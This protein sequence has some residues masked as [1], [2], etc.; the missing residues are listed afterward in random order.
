MTSPTPI[1]YK[2]SLSPSKYQNDA[3]KKF[4]TEAA[5][6]TTAA[7]VPGSAG[8]TASVPGH[9]TENLAA[10]Q[11]SFFIASSSASIGQVHATDEKDAK[12]E[13]C[14]GSMTKMVIDKKVFHYKEAQPL[15]PKIHR[16][17]RVIRM[18]EKSIAKDVANIPNSV[19]VLILGAGTTPEA[20]AAI[21]EH[22]KGL[23]FEKGLTAKTV[24]KIPV[25]KN[26]N[27]DISESSPE[28]VCVLGDKFIPHIGTKMSLESA[29]KL[30]HNY[31]SLHLY[32]SPSDLVL[33]KLFF[34]FRGNNL[35]ENIS[36]HTLNT[37]QSFFN[38]DYTIDGDVVT[39]GVLFPADLADKIT[40][41]PTLRLDLN[42]SPEVAKALINYGKSI[43]ILPD[44]S[45]EAIRC[46]NQSIVYEAI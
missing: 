6:S 11:A 42:V 4:K 8:A 5:A 20:A 35:L 14:A 10:S 30:H 16:S 22:I 40:N 44:M 23:V 33:K 19:L 29:S 17:A 18:D 1:N 7:N 21:P 36:I 43:S 38:D 31:F 25:V 9:A 41:L 37:I 39:L 2:R 13:D 45:L 26:R 27:V 15:G 32:D 28:V 46:L 3:N 34:S 24:E 12:G